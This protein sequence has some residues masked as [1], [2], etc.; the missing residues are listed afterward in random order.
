[1]PGLGGPAPQPRFSADAEANT[2]NGSDAGISPEQEQELDADEEEFRALRRDLDGVKGS[3]AIGV[4]AIAVGKTPPKNEFFRT[5]ATFRPIVPIV[6]IEKGMEK[7]YFAVAPN[8]VNA[9]AGIGITVADHTLY[10]TVTSEG[11]ITVV[12]VRQA[13]GDGERNEYDRTKEIGLIEARDHWIRLY[14]DQVNKVYK[15]YQ[16]P[17]GRFGDPLWLD[18]KHAKIFKLAFRD[19][20][21]LIDSAEHPLFLKWAASDRG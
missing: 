13:S 12:P 1:L 10:L 17:E 5:H 20:G 3:S 14:S 21:R 8:M 18:M 16:A 9:L 2:A 4:V 7:H 15:V 19:R 6:N 11:A